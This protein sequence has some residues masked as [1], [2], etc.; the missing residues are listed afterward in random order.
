MLRIEEIH[1]ADVLRQVAVLLE[2]ENQRLHDRLQQLT[3]ELAS[4]R[5]QDAAAAQVD[6]EFLKELLARRERALFGDSSEK[7]SRSERPAETGAAP[8]TWPPGH[9]PKAQPTLPLVETMHTLT[10]SDRVCPHCGGT[11]TELAHQTEDADEITV[12][13]RQFVLVRHR[14]QKYR[15]RCNGYVA[16][17][18]GPLRLATHPDRRGARYSRSSRSRSR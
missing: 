7:R 8:S 3:A 1:D 16:T 11:L 15:C 6:L 10:E 4:L 2:R 18:P 12:V 13:E 5:G 17:A 9:G 14:R